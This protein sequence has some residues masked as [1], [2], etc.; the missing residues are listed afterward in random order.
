MRSILV[1]VILAEARIQYFK[2]IWTSRIAGGDA[3]RGFFDTLFRYC[4]LCSLDPISFG[5]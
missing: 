2:Q 4:R 1:F 5:S 3:L